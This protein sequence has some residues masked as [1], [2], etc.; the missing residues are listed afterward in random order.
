MTISWGF[1]FGKGLLY[2]W[3]FP[4]DPQAGHIDN[5]NS[6]LYYWNYQNF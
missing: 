1:S 5:I 2:F 6:T 3:A 4:K